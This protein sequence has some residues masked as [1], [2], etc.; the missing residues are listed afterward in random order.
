[1]VEDF[2]LGYDVPRVGNQFPHLDG[3]WRY[4][5]DE[6]REF[7]EITFVVLPIMKATS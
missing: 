6:S 4:R 3:T 1:V 7:R 2:L 5:L